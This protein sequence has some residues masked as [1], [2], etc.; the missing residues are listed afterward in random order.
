MKARNDGKGKR[1]VLVEGCLGLVTWRR[2]NVDGGYV[3][4]VDDV[5]GQWERS[6]IE[7]DRV[8]LACWR[9][10]IGRSEGGTTR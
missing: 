5:T 3:L 9:T 7:A 1:W 2:W 8:G 6:R 4:E 10:T